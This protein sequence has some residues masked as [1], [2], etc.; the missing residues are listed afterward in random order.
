MTGLTAHPTAKRLIAPAVQM[1][2]MVLSALEAVMLLEAW[3]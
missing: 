3:N 2:V 1:T